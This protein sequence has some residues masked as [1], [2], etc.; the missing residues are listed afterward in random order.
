MKIFSNRT[1]RIGFG[2]KERSLTAIITNFEN[3]L[4][5]D[6]LKTWKKY[7]ISKS[8]K[9]KPKYKVSF[10][11]WKIYGGNADL[12]SLSIAMIIWA[13]VHGIVSLEIAGNL[14]PFGKKG[15]ALYLFDLNSIV[16]Q[17]VKE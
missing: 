8:P 1:H 12:L 2:Y 3:T 6:A 10:E 17:F 14:P 16:R 11:A 5:D 13:R 15:D 7:N 4:N 9:I